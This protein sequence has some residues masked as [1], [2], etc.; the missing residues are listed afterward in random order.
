[1]STIWPSARHG[2]S[3]G[4]VRFYAQRGH[5]VGP[6]RVKKEADVRR[7]NKYIFAIAAA[8]TFGAMI[9]VKPCDALTSLKVFRGILV[10]E[11][12]ILPGDYNLVLNFLSNEFN[13]SKISGGL[14]LASRGGHAVEAMKIG[15]LIRQLQLSTDAPSTPPLG[16]RI[17]GSAA[18]SATDLVDRREY[19]CASACFLIY[20][21]GIH[22]NLNG[23]G[24]LG[25]HQPITEAEPWISEDV[26]NRAKI[27]VRNEIKS[28]LEKM[29][30]PEKYLDLMYSVP[31]NK[32]RWVTQD[33]FDADLKGYVPAI[34]DVIEAKCNPE[35]NETKINLTEPPTIT[36]EPTHEKII[37]AKRSDE[38]LKCLTQVTAQLP[39]EAWR[40]MFKRPRLRYDN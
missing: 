11:G 22:R 24:R 27:A 16:K 30:V 19:I 3:S 9:S 25:I 36:L 20:V 32:V 4:E 13:F 8:L 33:E 35:P 34:K 7:L 2:N 17:L 40:K 5:R 21:A 26:V 1:M 37:S 14:F 28:Y 18:I 6:V 15:L 39:K 29:N 38:I 10:L 23:V 12:K 31:P